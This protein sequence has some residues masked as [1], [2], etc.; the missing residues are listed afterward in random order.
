[1]DFFNVYIVGGAGAALAIR[2][3][4]RVR[5]VEDT[6]LCAAASLL[7]LRLCFGIS[8]AA[9][10]IVFTLLYNGC[11][12]LPGV[13]ATV[14]ISFLTLSVSCLCIAELV[15][16][17]RAPVSDTPGRL[18][19]DKILF[20]AVTALAFSVSFYISDRIYGSTVSTSELPPISTD[21][22]ALAVQILC[23]TAV[24]CSAAVCRREAE[25]AAELEL[26]ASYARRAGEMY[27][28][29]VAFRHDIKNHLLI[30][31]GLLKR[32]RYRQAAD[33][34]EGLYGGSGELSFRCC[35]GRSVLDVLLEEKL[36]AAERA[37]IHTDCSLKV[38]KGFSAEDIDLCIIM[39]NVLD[40]AISACKE[41]KGGSISVSDRRSDSLYIITAENSAPDK[42]A[43]EGTGLKNI[44]AAAG[45]YGGRV[46]VKR[47]GETFR[48][49]V[50]FDI[51]RR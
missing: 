44:R 23:L 43:A 50:V 19:F 37:G 6:L 21:I 29:T 16:N 36:S 27:S 30:I 24:M 11:G 3:C 26:N 12:W 15:R 14:C 51:S 33:Y 20:A 4:L 9:E 49:T 32:R 10:S 31:N 18:P 25:K 2:A 1:M 45:R 13:A 41:L 28:K 39:S 7:I 17:L 47:E 8:G 48:L 22:C 5:G 34:A 42:T 35:T 46:F 38:P 40:N